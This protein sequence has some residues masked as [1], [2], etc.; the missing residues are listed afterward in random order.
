MAD[1]ILLMLWRFKENHRKA[2][3]RRQL[4]KSRYGYK[5]HFHDWKGK[6]NDVY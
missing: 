2:K 4:K 1:R 6:Y 5:V 3:R